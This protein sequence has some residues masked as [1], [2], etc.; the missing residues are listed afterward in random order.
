MIRDNT[1]DAIKSLLRP[2]DPVFVTGNSLGTALAVLVANDVVSLTQNF[3]VGTFAGPRIGLEDFVKSYN[4]VSLGRFRAV[5]RW[6]ITPNVPVPAPPLCLY[7]HVGSL[8]A[9]DGG[10]TLDLAH[11]HSLPLSYL[12]GLKKHAADWC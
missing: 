9:I 2:G 12:V 7:K 4:D 5:N 3:Q 11:A 8:L 10:F 1:L 6:N